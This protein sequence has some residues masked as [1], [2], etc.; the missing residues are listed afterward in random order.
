[1]LITS[2]EIKWSIQKM[3]FF[4]LEENLDYEIFPHALLICLYLH[5]DKGK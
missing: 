3:H 1:M 5:A 2:G 4:S